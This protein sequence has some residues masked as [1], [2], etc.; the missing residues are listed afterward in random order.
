AMQRSTPQPRAPRRR[1]I[2]ER[3]FVSDLPVAPGTVRAD[4]PSVDLSMNRRNHFTRSPP[5]ATRDQRTGSWT[6]VIRT[7]ARPGTP[8]AT[9]WRRVARVSVAVA[10]AGSRNLADC[11]L[12]HRRAQQRLTWRLDPG[13]GLRPGEQAGRP[14][15]GGRIRAPKEVPMPLG[16]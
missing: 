12:R 8:G 16:S 14:A 13:E 15:P 3:T 11:R 7:F 6:M 4:R 2:S 10:P 9:G 1:S 5:R